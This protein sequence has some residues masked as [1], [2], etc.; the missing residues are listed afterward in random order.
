MVRPGEPPS[1]YRVQMGDELLIAPLSYFYP[2]LLRITG[3]KSVTT[4]RP[5]EGDPEDPLDE[6]F[7]RETTVKI[8]LQSL[9]V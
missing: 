3:P 7:L 4:Q 1:R 8:I 5:N 6:N 2:E 9:N